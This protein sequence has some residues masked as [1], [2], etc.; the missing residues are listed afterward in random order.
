VTPSRWLC[1]A[2]LV[3]VVACGGPPAPAATPPPPEPA[4]PP[5]TPT[6][7]MSVPPAS[8]LAVLRVD[9]AVVRSSDRY[10]RFEGEL[11]RELGLEGE[12]AAVR[13]L[14]AN[15][16][17][18]VGVIVPGARGH[19]GALVVHGRFTEGDFVAARRIAEA[20]HGTAGQPSARVDGGV[21]LDFGEASLARVGATTFGVAKGAAGRELLRTAVTGGPAAFRETL[22]EFGR[23]VGL[24]A[25][26]CQAWASQTTAVGEDLVGLVLAGDRP[27][28]VAEFVATVSRHL[29]L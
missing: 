25:G 1:V 26:S 23:R 22:A 14:L 24:P 12:D 2:T 7:L 28:M 27:R 19:D 18:A 29:G 17:E 11:V 8:A 21:L 6:D 9:L 15:A 3:A 16:D 13:A 10:G 20:E 4:G 5:V